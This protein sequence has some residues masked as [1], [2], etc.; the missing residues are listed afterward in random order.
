[1]FKK[2]P[3]C[4]LCKQNP[5]TAIVGYRSATGSAVSRWKYACGSCPASPDEARSFGFNDLFAS[6]SATV[7]T[8]ANLE[9]AG[10]T[11]WHSFMEMMQRL[12]TATGS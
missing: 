3:I 7:S 8:L 10:T 9:D 1:M 4:E 5:A 2:Q 12:R 6:P 11:D